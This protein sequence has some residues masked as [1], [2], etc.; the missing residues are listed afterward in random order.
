MHEGLKAAGLT[1]ETVWL[2]TKRTPR[3]YQHRPW[4][5]E[6]MTFSLKTRSWVTIEMSGTQPQDCTVLQDSRTS[7]FKDVCLKVWFLGET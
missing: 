2:H 4:E 6:V 3:L 5:V 7:E 1:L